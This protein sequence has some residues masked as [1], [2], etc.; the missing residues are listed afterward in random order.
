MLDSYWNINLK[1]PIYSSHKKVKAILEAL[2][3][4]RP[5]LAAFVIGANAFLRGRNDCQDK[6]LW[7]QSQNQV[8]I[9][10]ASP[11]QKSQE[12]QSLCTARYLPP[13]LTEGVYTFSAG[14]IP[15]FDSFIITGWHYQ[16]SIRRE[17][18]TRVIAIKKYPQKVYGVK[19]VWRAVKVCW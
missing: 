7:L 1:V 12:S 16:S 18:K 8:Y 6:D 5:L 3:A 9:H 14:F 11:F 15:Q 13:M 2:F 10:Q 19:W 4:S 17:S